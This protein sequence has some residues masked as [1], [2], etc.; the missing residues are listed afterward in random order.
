MMNFKNW[1]KMGII[2]PSSNTTVELEFTKV[3]SNKKDVF[4]S[5]H[6]SRIK[7]DNV[8]V[9]DL[10]K[11]E[12]ETERA[13]SELSSIIPDIVIYACTTGS[14]FK[15]YIQY[16]ELEE[17]IYNI[18]KTPVVVTS[19][20]VISALRKMKMRDIVLVTPYIDELN[21]KEV[22]FL[23]FHDINVV[24]VYG[25]N[26]I[27]NTEIGKVSPDVLYEFITSRLKEI[28]ANF[29]GIF[30]SCTNLRTFDI[31]SKLEE[32][33]GK[34]VISSNS[35]TLWEALN[36][37]DIRIPNIGLGMLFNT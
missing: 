14:F 30:I 11:M 37:L 22:E 21:K 15:N 16:K 34:P 25:M 10:T 29:D 26:I 28:K 9:D 1:L 13:A 19:G 31:I 4:I 17:R 36:K 7:L 35:A 3:L 2:I 23:A 6:F 27:K 18:T 24:K 12:K 32:K 33:I 8:T 20:A 5:C